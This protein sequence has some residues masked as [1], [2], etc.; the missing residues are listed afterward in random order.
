VTPARFDAPT[1]WRAIDFL[2][3]LHLDADH[4]RTFAAWQRHLL[5]TPADAVFLL[6]DIFE[7]WVG[8]DAAEQPGSF[9]HQ[10]AQVLREAAQ[11]R[12][13][14][15]MHGNRDFLVGHALLSATGAMGLHDPTLAHA[16]GQALL[17][18]HGDALCLEDKD[19]Q[20]FRAMVRNP[21]WQQQ[22]LQ[23]PLAHRRALARQLRQASEAHQAG[24]TPQQWADIDP[25]EARHW[26]ATA[27]TTELLHGHTHRPGTTS[28]GD[29][30]TR[31]VLSDWD[32]DAEHRRA[33]VLRWTSSGL[34]RLTPEQALRPL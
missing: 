32:C 11:R 26:L 12:T 6:G 8:D 30:C 1:H 16:F 34:Q 13:I 19:Y 15:L 23:Q 27:G 20:R 3:D 28:L 33:E 18:T 31:H 4:P 2:S 7:A 10:C 22:L 14:G 21:A 24:Q 29:G 5:D 9:E 25:A 17:L